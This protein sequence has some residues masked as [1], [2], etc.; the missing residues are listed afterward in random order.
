M[1]VILGMTIAALI[2]FVIV[3]ALIGAIIRAAFRRGAD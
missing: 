3:V 2:W 1:V